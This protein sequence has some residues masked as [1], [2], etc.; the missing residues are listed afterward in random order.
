MRARVYLIII[1]AFASLTAMA[2][3]VTEEGGYYEV[4]HS[5][6]CN[7]KRCS[8]TLN[9][10]TNL[11]DYYQNEREHLAYRY[12]FNGGEIPPN[13]FSF[14][15]SEHDREIMQALADEFMKNI[16]TISSSTSSALLLL[17]DFT[18]HHLS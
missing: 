9:I 1:I 7:G 12:Q 8:V 5:W 16:T 14:M 17:P 2:H 18:Y 13:Y 10:S 15:L 4:E 11:Y 6:V 3:S